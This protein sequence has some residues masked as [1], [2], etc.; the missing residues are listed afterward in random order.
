MIYMLNFM[1]FAC[2]ALK[3]FLLTLYRADDTLWATYILIKIFAMLRTT[4]SVYS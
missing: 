3:L 2:G 4:D 1:F